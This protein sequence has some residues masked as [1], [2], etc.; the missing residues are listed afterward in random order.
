[1]NKQNIINL[2]ECKDWFGDKITIGD[3]VIP[4]TSEYLMAGIKGKITEIVQIGEKIYISLKDIDG[5]EFKCVN[6]AHY[7][8]KKN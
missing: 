4:I 7:I 1:M 6:V 8:K 3:Y 2:N 5:Y